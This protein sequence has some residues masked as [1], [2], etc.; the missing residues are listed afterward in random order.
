MVMIYVR[1]HYSE[2]TER[3]SKRL[4]G[5]IYSYTSINMSTINHH[6]MMGNATKHSSSVVAADTLQKS[7]MFV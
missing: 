6:K 4:P 7:C 2:P 3:T 1:A 5:D